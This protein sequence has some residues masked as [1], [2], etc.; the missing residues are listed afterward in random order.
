[1]TPTNRDTATCYDTPHTECSCFR[2]GSESEFQEQMLH[3]AGPELPPSCFF[4]GQLHSG[5][6]RE[7]QQGIASDMVS[8]SSES[9]Q[10]HPVDN[11]CDLVEH[12]LHTRHS[13]EYSALIMS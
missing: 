10:G 8:D 1:M 5:F 2:G 9:S 13:T 4:P 12:F 3:I 7:H 6:T 11:N